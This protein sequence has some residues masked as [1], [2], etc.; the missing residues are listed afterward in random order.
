VNWER[1]GA[2]RERERGGR[3]GESG[4]MEER[5]RKRDRQRIQVVIERRAYGS[6]NEM[7]R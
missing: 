5:E 7:E 2:F 4:N 3:R 6:N 1:N